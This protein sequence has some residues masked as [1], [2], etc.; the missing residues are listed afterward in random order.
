MQASE[1]ISGLPRHD[2]CSDLKQDLAINK[3][4]RDMFAAMAMQGLCAEGSHTTDWTVA[5]AVKYADALIAK[6]AEGKD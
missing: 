2:Q 3:S 1:E 5:R 4:R 6:L